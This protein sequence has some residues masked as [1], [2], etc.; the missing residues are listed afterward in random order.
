[1]LAWAWLALGDLERAQAA[2]D[3]ALEVVIRLGERGVE[4]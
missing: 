2:V 4:R 1:V 3:A